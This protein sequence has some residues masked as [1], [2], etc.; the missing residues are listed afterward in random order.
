MDAIVL[1]NERPDAFC[2]KQCKGGGDHYCGNI[3]DVAVYITGMYKT[4]FLAVN[5][6]NI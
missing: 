5:Y 4:T 1:G 3:K 2:E 6:C